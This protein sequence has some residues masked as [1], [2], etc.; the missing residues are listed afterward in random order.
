MDFGKKEFFQ[1]SFS[2]SI[3]LNSIDF[4]GIVHIINIKL[5]E[6]ET[7]ENNKK[8]YNNSKN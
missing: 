7:N 8:T 5:N 1:I 4:D 6:M 3:A 2:H